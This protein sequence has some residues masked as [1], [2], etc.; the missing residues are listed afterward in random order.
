[1]TLKNDAIFKVKLTDGLKY[2]IRKL[3]N[4]HTNSRK[5]ENLYF[6]T[7]MALKSDSIKANSREICMFCVM[8]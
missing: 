2:E 7:L 3:I 6:D 5:S 4:F 1:M 8:Q